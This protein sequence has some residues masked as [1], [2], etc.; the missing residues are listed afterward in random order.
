MA[1]LRRGQ[2]QAII[3]NA[4]SGAPYTSPHGVKMQARII[5]PDAS[6]ARNGATVGPGIFVL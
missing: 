6:A 4:I 3:G 1:L 2:Y 5:P